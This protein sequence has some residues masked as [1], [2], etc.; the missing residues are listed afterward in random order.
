MAE[1]NETQAGTEAAPESGTKS[2]I[3][4]E[5]SNLKGSEWV[6]RAAEYV[7]KDSNAT[8][9]ASLT[10]GEIYEQ[11]KSLGVH[12]PVSESTF[13]SY[14]SG[15][16]KQ[17][18]APFASHGKGRS[19][20]YFLSDQSTELAREATSL[21]D[22]AKTAE[23]AKERW[24]YPSLVAWLTG[25]GFQAKDTSAI[26][27]RELGKWGNP[28]VTG[29]AI[30]EHLSRLEI[31]V[32]TIE[33]KLGFDAWEVDF[34][35]AVSQKRFSNR[36]YFAF[37]L[38]EDLSE[39]LP[40]DLRY[41]SELFGVGV[42]VIDLDNDVYQR[43]ASGTLTPDDKNELEDA[44]GSTV[45][46]VLSAPWHSV[47]AAYHRRLCEAFSIRDTRALMNWGLEQR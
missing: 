6:A 44:D 30:D 47:P 26:R 42:L 43:L 46:E 11:V 10:A 33:A 25:Q 17:I 5:L 29:F 18:E 34:F 1:T 27:S 12:I 31:T 40:A 35:Q 45:R 7:L 14:L 37:A 8:K 32:A 22:E 15:I 16:V 4:D 39:K 28:D 19:G 38:P 20:G 21:P 24:L 41:Y 13:G 36:T 2:V 9:Q 3:F 23:R